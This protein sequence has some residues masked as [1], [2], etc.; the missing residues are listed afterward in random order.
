MED[1]ESQDHL[2][3]N[4]W[5][6]YSG[7]IS[8]KKSAVEIHDISKNLI[9]A[10]ALGSYYYF[11]VNMHDYSISQCSDSILDIHGGK[12]I[13]KSLREVI[14]LVH[15]DDTAYVLQAEE[16]TLERIAAVGFE[17]H[18]YLKT[19]YNFRM[20]IHDGTYRLFHH[21]AIRLAIDET[22][23]ISTVLNIHTDI[24]HITKVNNYI[25]LVTGVGERND[26]FQINLSTDT[27]SLDVPRLSKREMEVLALLAN[28][29]SSQMIAD[30]LFISVQTVHVHRK[31]LL[32]KTNVNN[33][34]ALIKYGLES[35]LV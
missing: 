14:D 1:N 2:L 30:K 35:G 32:K 7:A 31:N 23:S 4:L 16:A 9:D 20:R 22:G 13:P 29:L 28:G 5:E 3:A 18:L 10:F 34:G 8:R 21:Q 6:S 24:Q 19:A 12:K 11:I 27:K 25:A 17:N 26:Y 33:V 15:P